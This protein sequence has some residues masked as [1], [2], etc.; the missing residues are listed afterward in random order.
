MNSYNSTRHPF[1][2]GSIGLITG[3]ALCLSFSFYYSCIASWVT[4]IFD[5]SIT[6][7]SDPLYKQFPFITRLLLTVL[8]D[9][10]ALY[11]LQTI[12]NYKLYG[13]KPDYHIEIS[14]STLVFI[15]TLLI[16][17]ETSLNIF[18]FMQY[19]EG[20]IR[21]FY[22]FA[23]DRI[24]SIIMVM[25]FHLAFCTIGISIAR[26]GGKISA[27]IVLFLFNLFVYLMDIS[28]NKKLQ[29]LHHDETYIYFPL[30]IIAR[31]ITSITSLGI[32]RI[33]G[34]SCKRTIYI[35]IS[36]WIISIPIS[37]Y[38]INQILQH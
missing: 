26:K 18:I 10:I 6:N 5:V 4:E 20:I 1:L 12:I 13:G 16:L 3:I 30:W 34:I 15:V 17:I 19:S 32:L 9:F 31:Q 37:Y 35:V 29:T 38:Y 33:A 22:K 25:P 27:G 7:I 2:W 11:F 23:S 36:A 21:T 24:L 8:P 14:P 28:I